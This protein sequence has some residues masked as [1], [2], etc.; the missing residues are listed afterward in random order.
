MKMKKSAIMMAGCVFALGSLCAG[1]ADAKGYFHK[2]ELQMHMDFARNKGFKD[3]IGEDIE[4]DI[5]TATFLHVSEWKYGDV[6]AWM[7]IEGKDDYKVE[8]AQYYG[9]ISAR[10][11]LDKIIQGPENGTNMFGSFL[12]ESYVK[13]EYNGGTPV[14][15]FDFIDD[16]LLFGVSFDLGLGQPNFGFTNVSF[17]LKD[18][19]IIDE[20]ANSDLTWQFTL[21]WGQP[22]SLG[23]VNLDFQGFVDVWEYNDE[24]VIL[25]EPQL[26]LKLD[27]FVGKGNFL[28]DSA[29]G[30]ELEISNRF[31]SQQNSDLIFNPTI[32]WVTKF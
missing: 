24:I 28:S 21:A 6:F 15:G 7:D 11:S 25:S 13:V 27:S 18:Y 9:E 5:L 23:S 26:R 17:M 4:T 10:F 14:G 1:A 19:E 2:T 31:F 20:E 30:I 12:K 32:F 16:A 8:P 22:F 29:I 3:A